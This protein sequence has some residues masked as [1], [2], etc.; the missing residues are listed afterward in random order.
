MTVRILITMKWKKIQGKCT[1]Q[2]EDCLIAVLCKVPLLN[3]LLSR[4]DSMVKKFQN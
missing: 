2:T 3:R 4:L 1:V